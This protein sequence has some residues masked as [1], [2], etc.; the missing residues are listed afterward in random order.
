[1]RGQTTRQARP[2]QSETQTFTRV[3]VLLYDVTVVVRACK[4][5]EAMMLVAAVEIEDLIKG[6]KRG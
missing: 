6:S 3:H 2:S 5:V 4:F 1:M